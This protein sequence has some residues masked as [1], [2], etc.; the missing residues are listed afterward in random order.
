MGVLRLAA[1]GLALLPLGAAVTSAHP[2]TGIVVDKQGNVFFVDG[3]RNRILKV[4]REGKLSVLAAAPKD[5]PWVG[6]P[7][8]LQNPHRLSIDAKGNLYTASDAGGKVWKI[9]P[10]GQMTQIYPPT[11]WLGISLIGWGGDPFARDEQGNI[12]WVHEREGKYS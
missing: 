11:D 6:D 5:A 3:V 2:G 1:A 12:Y 8:H 10:D 9:A 4:D 7:A